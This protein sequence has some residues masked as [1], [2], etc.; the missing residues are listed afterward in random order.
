M[1]TLPSLHHF[2]IVSYRNH[3]P[4]SKTDIEGTTEYNVHIDTASQA[5]FSQFTMEASQQSMH[6]RTP[7]AQPRPVW[8]E[9]S[10]MQVEDLPVFS[11]LKLTQGKPLNNQSMRSSFFG[12]TASVRASLITSVINSSF[13]GHQRSNYIM[14]AQRQCPNNG[15]AILPVLTKECWRYTYSLTTVSDVTLDMF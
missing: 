2:T 1:G 6:A 7:P 10:F 8:V 11:E 4:I 3:N 13:R 12:I 5:T 15:S 9:V 14:Q